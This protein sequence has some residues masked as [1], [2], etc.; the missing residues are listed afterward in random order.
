MVNKT[1]SRKS[2]TRRSIPPRYCVEPRLLYSTHDKVYSPR[3]PP[4]R[5]NKK[6]AL[7]LVLYLV[8]LTNLCLILFTNCFSALSPE[9]PGAPAQSQETTTADGGGPLVLVHYMPWYD[10]PS[11]KAQENELRVYGGHW[12]GWGE[13]RCSETTAEGK[14]NIYARQYPL[15]GPYDGDTEILL[16][17]Q[18]ALMKI[19]GIDGVIF[20]WYG[21]NTVNDFG[22]IHENTKA[23]VKVLKS[24][25]LKFL[26]C[27]EDNTL[28]MTNY[29][30][31]DPAAVA[32][33]K[34]VFDWAQ[35]NWFTD[36]A[37][38]HYKGRPVVVCFG[39][40]YFSTKA[41]WEEVFSGVDPAPYFGD[42]DNRYS[43][44]D[45]S[46]NWMPMSRSVNGVLSQESL[47]RYLDSF[48]SGAQSNKPYRMATA[49][50][51]F[52]DCY[53]LIGGKSYGALDYADGAVF[54]LTFEKAAAQ[55]PQIIQIATW[56]DYG[57]GTIIEPT[58]ERGYAELEYLQDRQREWDADFPFTKEDLRYPLEFYKL[59][60]TGTADSSERTAIAAAY[61][62][63]FA[64]SAETFRAEAAKTGVTVDMRDLKPLL[65]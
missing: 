23:M 9:E 49:F 34:S 30:K 10:G 42:L 31:N 17:Y 43:W 55:E 59:L 56:N 39:P 36:A 45:F 57:E 20:D 61:A 32:V 53:E 37:Y 13:I 18:T 29:A 40:Q 60:Y 16:Q 47:N 4:A 5:F 7:L 26:L 6:L 2:D 62:A 24:A 44:A 38:V 63:V 33:G 35:K 51:A 11:T 52:D 46:Y 22:A 14:A 41:Q 65:R 15:T 1:T 54:A 48:Y 3:H 21:S 27:Y 58:I 28:N 12:T 64:G 50:S 25:N 8:F 19:A